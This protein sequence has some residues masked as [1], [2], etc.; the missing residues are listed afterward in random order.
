MYVLNI[1]LNHHITL[2]FTLL[3]HEFNYAPVIQFCC[4]CTHNDRLMVVFVVDLICG[5]F[6]QL[7]DELVGL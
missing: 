2:L 3:K 6:S 1:L 7:M 5:L 4:E